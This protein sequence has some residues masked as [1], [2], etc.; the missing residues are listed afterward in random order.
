MKFSEIEYFLAPSYRV[1]VFWTYLNDILARYEENDLIYDPDFQR[2]YVWTEEQQTQYVEYV[3][4]GGV[5][6]KDIYFNHPFWMD[7]SVHGS[8]V[9]VDGKQRINAV[10]KF[11]NNKLKAFNY[12]FKEFEGRLPDS[13]CF[14]NFNVNNLKDQNDVIK[15]YISMNSGGSVHTEKD[16]K[17][18]R[19]CIV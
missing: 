18:A 17:R 10:Q 8:M 1:T 3:F 4:K 15:W 9:L 11:L 16:I 2:G 19:D 13:T 6:G 14:F 12:L 5:S 7:F